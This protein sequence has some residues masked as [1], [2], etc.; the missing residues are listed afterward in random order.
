MMSAAC[1]CCADPRLAEDLRAWLPVATDSRH[2]TSA[3]VKPVTITGGT[4]GPRPGSSTSTT[5]GTANNGAEHHHAGGRAAPGLAARHPTGCAWRSAARAREEEMRWRASRHARVV[6]G[7]V[8]YQPGVNR[9]SDE[10]HRQA[11]RAA[12][13]PPSSGQGEHG[14]RH[15]D[16]RMSMIG[17]DRDDGFRGGTGRGVDDGCDDPARSARG[18]TAT[19]HCRWWCR[20]GNGFGPTGRA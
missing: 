4:A 15:D 16:R 5:S 19:T 11:R 20:A 14:V 1:C 8:R 9:V 12:R 13:P 7:A 18:A 2:E 10:H 6:I 3:A 17:Y